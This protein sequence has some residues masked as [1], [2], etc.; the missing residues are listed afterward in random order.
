M[1]MN[2]L[3]NRGDAGDSD[4]ARKNE[5]IRQIAK[6]FFE[7][8][9][10]KGDESAIDKFISVNTF[11]NDPQF[12]TGRESFRVKWREWQIAFPDIHFR[13]DDVIVEG[14][15]VVTKWHL[16]GTQ[17]GPLEGQ[18]PSN[19]KVSV[20]GVSIDKVE[21]GLV[22]SGFDAWDSLNFRKQLGLPL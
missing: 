10:N 7:E 18:P 16:T 4:I 5:E 17:T 15:Q 20:D 3:P 19:K 1:R 13:I 21:G 14:N 6:D 12:G 9:W 22:V 8:I 11:G 2:N